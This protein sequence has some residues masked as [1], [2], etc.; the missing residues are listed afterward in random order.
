MSIAHCEALRLEN[1]FLQQSVDER[2]NDE[3]NLAEMQKRYHELIDL[4]EKENKRLKNEVIQMT[5]LIEQ[6]RTK[7]P[8]K[9]TLSHENSELNYRRIKLLKDDFEKQMD[10]IKEQHEIS[11]KRLKS[12]IDKL[13]NEKHALVAELDA[14]KRSSKNLNVQRSNVSGISSLS[15]GTLITNSEHTVTNDD[16]F[17]RYNSDDLLSQKS[18]ARGSVD[19]SSMIGRA[20]HNLIDSPTQQIRLSLGSQFRM[21]DQKR[22]KELENLLDSHIEA[23]KKSTYNRNDLETDFIK[24]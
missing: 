8:A 18:Q 24:A 1:Q 13:N 10:S 4:S 7:Q 22:K 11:L 5:Q 9:D 19:N 23:L 14:A 3:H 15:N 20:R 6:L 21:D 2:K 17:K 12:E 16:V